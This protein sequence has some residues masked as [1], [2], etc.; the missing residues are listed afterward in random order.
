MMTLGLIQQHKAVPQ[1]GLHMCSSSWSVEEDGA[2]SPVS[3]SCERFLTLL[4]TMQSS[5]GLESVNNTV[6]TSTSQT[7]QAAHL[8]LQQI[9]YK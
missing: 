4:Y 5:S 9:P 1:Q 8:L 7:I 6:L 2:R 3:Q